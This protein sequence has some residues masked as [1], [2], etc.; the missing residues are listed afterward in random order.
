MVA[1][2][3]AEGVAASSDGFE[4]L[5]VGSQDMGRETKAGKINGG[6]AIELQS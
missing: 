6:N 2:E 3:V 4:T 1:V 5:Q